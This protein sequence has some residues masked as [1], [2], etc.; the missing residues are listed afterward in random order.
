MWPFALPRMQLP[1]VKGWN[2]GKFYSNSLLRLE[3][4]SQSTAFHIG[5]ELSLLPNDGVEP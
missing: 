3:N 5:P 1:Q 2:L 4:I